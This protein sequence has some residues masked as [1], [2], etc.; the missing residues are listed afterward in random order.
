MSARFAV[1]TSPV[2]V[3]YGTQDT[4]QVVLNTGVSTV[5][6]SDNSNVQVGFDFPLGCGESV[7]VEA[8]TVLYATSS[9]VGSTLVTLNDYADR[10]GYP[11]PTARFVT[12]TTDATGTGVSGNVFYDPTTP[13]QFQ[14]L[15][16]SVRFNSTPTTGAYTFTFQSANTVGGYSLGVVPG[17][18]SAYQ[19]S[20]VV[21]QYAST[22]GSNTLLPQFGAVLPVSGLGGTWSVTPPSG[23]TAN[24]YTVDVVGLPYLTGQSSAWSKN[25]MANGTGASGTQDSKTVRWG[26]AFNISG[27]GTIAASSTFDVVLPAITG[28]VRI[29]VQYTQ[30]GAGASSAVPYM[31]VGQYNLMGAPSFGTKVQYDTAVASGTAAGTVVGFATYAVW[32]VAPT[33]L[34][35][36]TAAGVSLASIQI[37]IIS[38][39]A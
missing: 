26:N 7:V 12:S 3:L 14:S 36:T 17:P 32:P 39:V 6:L 28:P 25:A 34:R 16:L 9:G 22:G 20:E 5:Y 10:F 18:I 30:T 8:E 13:S 29:A 2:Q 19:T 38:G 31:G 4:A 1:G 33:Y 27:L 23:T 35:L 11:S 24:S 15:G 21:V 37:T